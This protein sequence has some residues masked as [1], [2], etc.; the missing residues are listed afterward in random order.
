MERAKFGNRV[1]Y[2]TDWNGVK[3]D[4]TDKLPRNQSP[5]AIIEAF[6]QQEV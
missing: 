1:K 4:R 3:Y 2:K 6:R 5:E